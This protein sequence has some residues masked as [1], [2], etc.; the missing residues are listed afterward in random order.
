L[1]LLSEQPEPGLSEP[2]L[3]SNLFCFCL[4]VRMFERAYNLIPDSCTD[5]TEHQARMK[6][7]RDFLRSNMNV[8]INI[9][10]LSKKVHVPKSTLATWKKEI[11]ESVEK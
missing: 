6:E 7:I 4:F 8:Y 2:S 5:T 10:E 1:A 9:T 3:V 11:R